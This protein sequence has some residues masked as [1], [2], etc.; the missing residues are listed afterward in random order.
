MTTEANT[1]GAANA[2]PNAPVQPANA[3]PAASATPVVPQVDHTKEPDQDPPW[4]AKRLEQ[5]KRVLT[6]ELESN[7]R[8]KALAD[9]GVDDPEKVKKILDD[10]RKREEAAKSQEQK[11]AE[12]QLREQQREARVKELEEAVKLDTAEQLAALTEEQRKAVVELA[13]EDPAK[14]RKA[15]ATLRPTWAKPAPAAQQA[16]QETQ[17][18]Q[19]GSASQASSVQQQT[20]TNAAPVASA[21]PA[22]ATAPPN[23]APPPAGTTVTPNHLETYNALNDPKSPNYAPHYAA[24]YY[25]RFQNEIVAAQ[26][27]RSAN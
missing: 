26:K 9:L 24:Q 12:Y 8:A 17:A 2:A 23:N 4:L 7:A 5:Q 1:N 18:N 14:Q 10:Q 22:T 6:K 25:A 15:I 16:T 13:G 19:N 21:K 20:Q 11:L 27:S 3:A